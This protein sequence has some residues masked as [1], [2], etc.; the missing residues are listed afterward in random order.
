M[1]VH[2]YLLLKRVFDLVVGI[3]LLIL[4]SPLF[5][6]V[7]LLI[8]VDSKGPAIFAQERVGRNGR[9]FL[10]Y[11]FRSMVYN[12]DQRKYHEFIRNAFKNEYGNGF[13]NNHVEFKTTD[14]RLTKLGKIIRLTSIDELPQ[15]FNVIKGEMSLIGPRPDVPESVVYYTDFEKKRLRVKPGITGWWQVS[16]RSNLS[17]N[18]MFVLDIYYVENQNLWLDMKIFFKTIYVVISMRGSG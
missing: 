5:L 3:L 10:C 4:L 15:I 8:K 12:A 17:L 2:S 14:N 16:G 11:K 6:V 1:N 13:A 9:T 18:E 7:A